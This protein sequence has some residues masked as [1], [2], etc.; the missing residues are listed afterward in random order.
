VILRA[1]AKGLTSRQIASRINFSEST[2]RMESMAIY[3]AYGVHSRVDAVAAA[4]AAGHLD[5]SGRPSLA[6]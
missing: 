1:M 4:R 3:R 5:E 6:P 2:V